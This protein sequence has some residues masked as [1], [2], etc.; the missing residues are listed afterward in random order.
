MLE[1]LRVMFEKYP[2]GYPVVFHLEQ[3]PGQKQRILTSFRIAFDE[4]IEKEL[5]MILG[6]DTVHIDGS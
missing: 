2:G 1:Q 4:L 5:E 6:P 3:V